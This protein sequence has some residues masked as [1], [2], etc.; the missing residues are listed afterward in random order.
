VFQRADLI[1]HS[2]SQVLQNDTEIFDTSDG[3]VI[4]MVRYRIP[5]FENK[6]RTT[7]I[8][9]KFLKISDV[10]FIMRSYDLIM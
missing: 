7:G 6:D 4:V 9:G 8:N 5:S 2:R 1:G 10:I 3:H